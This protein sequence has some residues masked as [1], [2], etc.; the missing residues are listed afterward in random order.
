MAAIHAIGRAVRWFWEA[1]IDFA[2]PPDNVADEDEPKSAIEELHYVS[3]PCD[4]PA[5]MTYG[6]SRRRWS[7]TG[8]AV[9][10]IGSVLGVLSRRPSATG[11][12]ES[13]FFCT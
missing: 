1:A 4:R 8:D 10:I 3:C 5:G 9:T 12:T 13:Q 6:R 11:V 2:F 7:H